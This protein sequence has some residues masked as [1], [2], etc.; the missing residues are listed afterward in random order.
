MVIVDIETDGLDATR[1]W[2]IVCYD[3]ES[4]EE[5][6]FSSL[7]GH[8][9]ISMF[10]EYAKSV[11]R[12]V[13][14]NGLSFDIPV[15]NRLLGTNIDNRWPHVVDTFVV[16]RLV[17]YSRFM[18]HGLE[19]LGQYL[20]FHKSEY[21]DWS[22]L[23]PEMV[24]YCRQDVRVNTRVYDMYKKYI[25][26]P[27]WGMSMKCE[28][29]M[30]LICQDM[31]RNGFHFNKELGE[32]VLSHILNRMAQLEAEFAVEMKPFLR[33]A[34]T[35]QYR[36]KKDGELY[37]TTQA[38]LDRY[39]SILQKGGDLVCY[40]YEPFNPASTRDRIEKLWE[41]GWN[42][43]EKSDT[44]YEFTVKAKPGAKWRKTKLT[45]MLYKEKLEYFKYYGWKVNETNLLTLPETA[46]E[47]A[48]KL[49]EW[50]TLNGRKTALEERLRNYEED[51]R[52][53]A[54]FWHIG[55]W[56]G[57]MAHSA[58]NLANISSPFHGEPTNAVE[59]VKAEY[60]ADLRRM[61]DVEDGWLVGTDADGIQLRILAHYMEN[62]EYVQAILEGRK[63]DGTDIHNVNRRALGLEHVTRD[64]AKTFIYAWLLG[65]GVGKVSRI[66]NCSM[67][68][69]KEAVDNFI[70][71]TEG[72]AALKRGR[73]KSDARRGYFVGLDDRKVLCNS[74]YLMLAGYLQNGEAVI[75]KHA[76]KLWRDWADNARINYKQVNFVHDEWQ[77]QVY[78]S[79]DAAE[80]LGLLQRNALEEVG[81]RLNT[82]CPIAGSTDIGKNWYDTH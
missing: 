73:I 4:K 40:Q 2:C 53:H 9:P 67:A 18:T 30:A 22:K 45:P 75:M 66:L 24:E 25:L 1:I 57:R 16:S 13:A 44:H 21:S 49:A 42:P 34:N 23:T 3:V 72:L 63:E 82:Y 19:E 10:P 69:A 71:R 5:R 54:S 26:D 51:E 38:A 37:S 70:E 62:D 64:N 20:R 17:N 55:A 79:M 6:V 15:L 36:V 35:V 76:N 80:Y 77:T 39:D 59:K 61:F 43:V 48:F 14:H 11:K 46:P 7:D 8:L 52:I 12:W 27:E 47:A 50:L 68:A 31:K 65:A 28:H 56:T 33:Y 78:D 81:K 74:D 58:P 41:F 32:S 60:D 29:D